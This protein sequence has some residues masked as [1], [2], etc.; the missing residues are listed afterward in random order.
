M[1]NHSSIL[2]WKIPW[3]EE[4]GELQSMGPQRSGVT[5]TH[6]QTHT[7]TIIIIKRYQQSTKVKE[8][9]ELIF[10]KCLSSGII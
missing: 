1:V 4:L 3:A 10:R 8:L 2:A 7:H 5:N 9:I 6:T